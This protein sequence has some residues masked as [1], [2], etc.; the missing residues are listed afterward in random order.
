MTNV[1]ISSLL[2]SL[3]VLTTFREANQISSQVGV[4]FSGYVDC[5]HE[6]DGIP[7]PHFRK[8]EGC[9]HYEHFIFISKFTATFRSKIKKK[10]LDY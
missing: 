2:I 10:I 4:E 8:R 7:W 9:L 1:Y 5:P 6:P 3:L